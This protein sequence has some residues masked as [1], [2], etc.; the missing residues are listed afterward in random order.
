[1]S[2]F[3]RDDCD[4]CRQI[5]R[6]IRQIQL[7]MRWLKAGME[8]IGDQLRL[9]RAFLTE[10]LADT[11]HIV[12]LL[13]PRLARVEI[14]RSGGSPMPLNVGDT[15]VAT[16]NGF[17]QFRNPFPIDF[18]ATPAAWSVSDP[19]LATITAGSTPA[20]ENVTGVAAGSETLSVTVA[21]QSAS[22]TFDVVAAAPVLTSVTITI[23]PPVA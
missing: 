22:V 10:I 9:Q 5:E 17:D 23:N 3:K 21:D 12:S 18:S 20:D 14:I 6:D 19:T 8:T 15:V 1:M 7:D 11:H 2:W 4:C 16:V 13:Q